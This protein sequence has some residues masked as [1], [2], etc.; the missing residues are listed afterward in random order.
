MLPIQAR[1]ANQAPL[2]SDPDRVRPVTLRF[3]V[4]A[5]ATSGRPPPTPAPERPETPPGRPEAPPGRPETAPAAGRPHLGGGAWVIGVSLDPQQPGWVRLAPDAGYDRGRLDRLRPYD[6]VRVEARPMWRLGCR[7]IWRPLLHSMRTE[8]HLKQW[9]P[10]RRWL[11][12]YVGGSMCRLERRPARGPSLALIRARDVSGLR[13]WPDRAPGGVRYRGAYRYRCHDPACPGHEHEI[14]DWDFLA[15]QRRL[16]ALPDARL[17][18]ALRNNYLY[19]MCA[20]DRAVAFYVGQADRPT[21]GFR[22]LGVYW[23]PR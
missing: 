23:P 10:R 21:D 6:V 13:L 19:R 20:P 18:R 15:L 8:H 1:E 7:E 4:A 12:P 22:V 2:R 11:E 17:R 5:K 16:T 14:V 9:Q 3:L